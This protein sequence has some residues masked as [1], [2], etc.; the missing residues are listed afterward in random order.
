MPQCSH[1][2]LTPER[3][4][5]EWSQPLDGEGP[6]RSR[7][8]KESRMS[9]DSRRSSSR[10]NRRTALGAAGAAATLMSLGQRDPATA[11]AATPSAMA[12]H[13]VV[14]AWLLMT[15]PPPSPATFAA[16]GLV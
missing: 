8:E 4:D 16:D 2:L 9:H 13:P 11:Q 10:L 3:T 1:Q 7:S 15:P 6:A 5:R 14:G 12:T